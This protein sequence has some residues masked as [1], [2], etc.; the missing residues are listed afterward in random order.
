MSHHANP[1]AGRALALLTAGALG[2]SLS[3]VFV[4]YAVIDGSGP[5]AVAFW[6]MAL[7]A[8]PLFA[9]AAVRRSP[10]GLPRPLLGLAVL[11]GVIF[12][13]DL[14]LW[15]RSIGLIGA[16]LAT[17]LGNT[18]VFN[19]A[20]LTWLVFGERPRAAFYPAAAAGLAGVA[21]LV[22]V[23]GPAGQHPDHVRG[24]LYGVGTGVAYAGYLVTTRTIARR[25][26]R[27]PM[28]VVVA[29][30]S[31]LGAAASLVAC[32]GETG[33]FWPRTA[34]AWGALA[35]LGVVVQA[36]SW[37][38]ITTALPQVPG[39]TAGL[40]L[41]L[42][43]ALAT[44]WGWLLFGER[45]GAAQLAGAALVLGAIYLGTTRGSS[46]SRS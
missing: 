6:R 15:H 3:P 22:G 37:W 2:I 20:L 38:A 13:I 8:A 34:R 10:L 43:P 7:G 28:L 45:L 16:G 9:L 21:L 35:G 31:L 14:A 46:R 41:L 4:K 11:A 25:P 36:A 5:T 23:G 32:A 39:A 12:T 27:P 29:W 18:Q 17:V 30:L 40:V 42:Q 19:T 24:V 44:V 26:G 33:A 1:G